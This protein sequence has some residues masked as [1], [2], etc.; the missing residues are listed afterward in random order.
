[1]KS[2]CSGGTCVAAVVAFSIAAFAQTTGQTQPQAGAGP[3]AAAPQDR[4]ALEQ[5]V[6]VVGCV[7][8]EADYRRARD[9]G[10]G[11]VAG[12]GVGVGNEFVLINASMS[13]GS[14]SPAAT[15]GTAA[16][17]PTGTAGAAASGMAYELTGASER[18][19]EQHVGRRVEVSGKLKAAEVE[20]SGR[21]TGGATAGKPPEGIEVAGQDL[22]LR[23]LEVAS[24]REVSGTCPAVQR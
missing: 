3:A 6:T 13:T 14:G 24:I 5:Q 8:R 10:R 1:M 19:A 12:T 7:Q 18:Q 20:P 16:G 21:P 2:R 11:G 15:A 4:T 17:T 23:E 9:A 22:K